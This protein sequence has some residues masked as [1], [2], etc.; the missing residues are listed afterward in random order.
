MRNSALSPA[1]QRFKYTE[2]DS[3]NIHIVPTNFS[4]VHSMQRRAKH[5]GYIFPRSTMGHE[6]R[7]SD[8]YYT[9]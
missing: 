2:A 8:N 5:D 9:A 7:A 1:Q 3:M 6:A 4:M